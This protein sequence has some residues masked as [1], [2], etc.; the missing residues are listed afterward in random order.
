MQILL[1]A[2]IGSRL[3]GRKLLLIRVDSTKFDKKKLRRAVIALI[4]D[5]DHTVV[6]RVG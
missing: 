4:R 2:K 5:Q 3:Q 1:K 6:P